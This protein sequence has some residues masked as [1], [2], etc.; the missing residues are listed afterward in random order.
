MSLGNPQKKTLHIKLL[1]NFVANYLKV[2]IFSSAALRFTIVEFRAG[3]GS[4]DG[5]SYVEHERG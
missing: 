3:G 1:M 2:L 4:Q 5:H